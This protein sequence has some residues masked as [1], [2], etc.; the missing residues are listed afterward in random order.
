M[1]KELFERSRN[2][3]L[4]ITEGNHEKNKLMKLLLFIFPE[5]P[6]KPENIIMYESN[7]YALHAAV[8]KKYGQTWKEQDVD[9]PKTISQFKS[10][11]QG[12][13]KINFTNV[14][15]I[16]DYERHDP[17]FSASII[18]EMQQYFVDLNDNGLLLINYPMVESYLDIDLENP[19]LYENKTE[20][21]NMKKGAEYKARINEKDLSKILLCQRRLEERL[22]ER[23]DDEDLTESLAINVMKQLG[24]KPEIQKSILGILSPY[25]CYELALS[26]SYQ[27]A[28]I[29]D[30]LGY[31]NQKYDYYYFVR[32]LLRKVIECNIRKANKLQ[33]GIYDISLEDLKEYYYD[34]ISYVDI[35]LKQNH[36]SRNPINGIIWVLNT[37]ILLVAN[38]KFFWR[39]IDSQSLDKQLN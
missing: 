27:Y 10:L 24:T 17:Q 31:D 6:I 8:V 1:N 4:V 20:K 39:E 37:S 38:Y 33:G 3:T 23:I 15:L 29:I 9:I 35:L 14:F 26:L 5:I 22:N 19:Q 18:N 7:I 21:A 36:D 16:F 32:A 11:G 2:K 13:E 30:G 25:I 12:F 34:H 28:A